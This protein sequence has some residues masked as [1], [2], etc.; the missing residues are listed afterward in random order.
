MAKI[1]DT[2]ELKF[3]SEQNYPSPYT[4]LK[5]WVEFRHASGET[6]RRP[7]FWD[8]GRNWKVRFASTQESGQ[9]TWQ[10]FA[11]K[12][13][14]GL[15]GKTGAFS[16]EPNSDKSPYKQHGLLRMSAGKRNATMPMARPFS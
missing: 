8:G 16:A 3:K 15:A 1:W 6:L 2:I 12:K 9:W 10:S 13:D 5:F 7:G 14:K 11:N 4:E